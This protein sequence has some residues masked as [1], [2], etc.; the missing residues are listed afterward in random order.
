MRNSVRAG[1]AVAILILAAGC[2][3]RAAEAAPQAPTTLEPVVVTAP[4]AAHPA[5][6]QR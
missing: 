5:R 6:A 4:A 3:S 1:G 2:G